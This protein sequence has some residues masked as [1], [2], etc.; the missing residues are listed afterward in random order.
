MVTMLVLGVLTLFFVLM[1]VFA[2]KL[3]GDMKHATIIVS[4]TL[5]MACVLTAGL[6]FGLETNNFG[7]LFAEGC[8]LF[9]CL[10]VRRGL[11]DFDGIAILY[12]AFA[13]AFGVLAGMSI[14]WR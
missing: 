9:L 13:L 7:M 10:M 11:K 8:A 12:S 5:A 1:A 3:P 4:L 2:K 6:A 14:F